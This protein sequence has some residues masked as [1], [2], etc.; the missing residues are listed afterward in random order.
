MKAYKVKMGYHTDHYGYNTNREKA[1]YFFDKEKALAR[2]KEGEFT[3][4]ETRIT[5]TWKDGTTT[6]GTT[7]AQFFEER[8][9][10]ARDNE[11]VELV[12]IVYNAY[13]LEEIEI[14]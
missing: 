11:V 6:A 4:K 14:N 7:G 13:A 9:A 5:T 8:K 12:D 1:E 10:N 3:R 2:Y